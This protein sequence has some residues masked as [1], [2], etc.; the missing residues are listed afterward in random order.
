MVIVDSADSVLMLYSYAGFMD[1]NKWALIKR[2]VH[3]SPPVGM[4]QGDEEEIKGHLDQKTV[5]GEGQPISIAPIGVWQRSSEKNLHLSAH[6]A[7]QI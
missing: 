4:R 6:G 5:T 7:S 1:Q 2:D 3:A